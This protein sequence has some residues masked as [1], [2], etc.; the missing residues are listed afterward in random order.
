MSTKSVDFLYSLSSYLLLNMVYSVLYI[1]RNTYSYLNF[2]NIVIP[3]RTHYIFPIDKIDLFISFR[4]TY[5]FP[6]LKCGV[7]DV[8]QDFA[9]SDEFLNKICSHIV[10]TSSVSYSKE[11]F[12]EN[13]K[14]L[15]SWILN[16]SFSPDP[17]QRNKD[18]LWCLL[19]FHQVYNRIL[20]ND[21]SK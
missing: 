3:N 14:N 8:I 9:Q 6:I 15:L 21:V 7:S 19:W 20:A 4:I 18:Q 16:I 5:Y 1:I 17:C 12:P 13:S 10:A 11:Y 2:S